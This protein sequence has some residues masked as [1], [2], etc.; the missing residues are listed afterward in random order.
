MNY[1]I[2]YNGFLIVLEGYIDANWIS[3]SDET[4]SINGVMC[5]NWVGMRLHGNHLNKQ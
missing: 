5:S 4:K 1:A 3:D 2:V